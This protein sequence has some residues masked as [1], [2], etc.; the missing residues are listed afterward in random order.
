MT[1]DSFG[2]Q[3]LLNII[4]KLLIGVAGA[5]LVMYFQSNQRQ[6]E[7][8][9]QERMAVGRV[10]TEVLA[11]QRS[12]LMNGVSDYAT[13]VKDLQVSGNARG[14]NA[15]ELSRLGQEIRSSIAVLQAIH[16][17]RR[18]ATC[19]PRDATVL[20]NFGTFINTK[21]TIPLL[22][23]GLEPKTLQA[24]LDQ[25]LPEYTGVLEFTRC[26]AVDTVQDEMGRAT[27]RPAAQ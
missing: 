2:G 27:S 8:V 25:L 23:E 20:E 26:L 19:E 22:A 24:R 1:H 16:T 21:L 5:A 9:S 11:D 4:D 18:L 12:R 13:L 3:V 17:T 15:E 6:A 14:K 10:V 7:I